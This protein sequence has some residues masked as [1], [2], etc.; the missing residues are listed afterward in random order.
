MTCPD[1]YHPNAMKHRLPCLLVLAIA[2]GA[3]SSERLLE[4]DQ[5]RLEDLHTG[6]MVDL[7]FVRLKVDGIKSFLGSK[8]DLQRALERAPAVRRVN[9]RAVKGEVEVT[10]DSW[11]NPQAVLDSL[12]PGYTGRVLEV[13][14][15]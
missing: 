6:E 12:P 11:G 7:K 8:A 4:R 1:G 2:V 13:R 3:C 10:M 14:E 15:R 5:Q 9:I